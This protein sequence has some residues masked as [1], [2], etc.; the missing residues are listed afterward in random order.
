MYIYRYYVLFMWRHLLWPVLIKAVFGLYP[1]VA[2]PDLRLPHFSRL[3][4]ASCLTLGCHNSTMLILVQNARHSS[5]NVRRTNRPPH[6]RRAA[7]KLG[8]LRTRSKQS[9]N[10]LCFSFFGTAIGSIDVWYMFLYGK[11]LISCPVDIV[12]SVV[13]FFLLLNNEMSKMRHAY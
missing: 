4:F 9:P 10:T 7:L 12:L 2:T 3:V 5:P 13:Q 1:K 6:M 11:Q 8:W